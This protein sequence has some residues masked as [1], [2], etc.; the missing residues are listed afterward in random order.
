MRGWEQ[1]PPPPLDHHTPLNSPTYPRTYILCAVVL[2][3]EGALAGRRGSVLRDG[4]KIKRHK[5][6][7]CCEQLA[8]VRHQT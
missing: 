2:H 8:A 5:V 1:A 7:G 4:A 6:L 3:P